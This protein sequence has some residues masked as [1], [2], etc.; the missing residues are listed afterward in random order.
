M[1]VHETTRRVS[2]RDIAKLKASGTKIV[3]LTAYTAPVAS[4]MDDHVDLILVGDS[5][6]MVIYGLDSTV[7]VTMEMMIAHGQ[8]VVRASRKPLVVV[9]MPFG[10]YQESPAQ[11]FA[12]AARILKETGCTAVKLEGGREMA[13][14][15]YFLTQ[16]GIPVMGHIGLR[17][18][19]VNSAGGY[20]MIGRKAEEAENI[21]ADA[22]A[23]QAAG[24]F[25]AVLECVDADLADELVVSVE[26]PIIGIGGTS[27]CAGQILVT[28]DMLG[29]L[30]SAPP[31]FVRQYANLRQQAS[32]AIARYADDVRA[33]AF[34]GEAEIYRRRG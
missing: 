30:G 11:A 22:H 1:S 12:N 34:P 3:C 14:T 13:D 9:D 33:A 28:D 27:A 18:Q 21:H 17:P 2:V 16:R 23:V 15:I 31:R 6:G 19:S 20:R 25:S 5:L 32:T 8:A 10:S 29:L 4:L 26:M 24:A 7:P